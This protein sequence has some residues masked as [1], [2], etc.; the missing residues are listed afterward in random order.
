[1]GYSPERAEKFHWVGAYHTHSLVLIGK[2]SKN[3]R[4]ASLADAQKYRVGAVREDIG[5]QLLVAKGFAESELALSNIQNS[6]FLKLQ[7]DRLDLI[8]YM[9]DVA[10]KNMPRSGLDPQKYEIVFQVHELK[11]GFGFSKQIPEGVIK[12]FQDALNTL[13]L[14][15]SIDLILKKYDIH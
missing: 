6:L 3:I 13:F 5:H 8:S 14:D 2:K 15:G 7:A 12:Q 10:F 4:I 1:M 9:D 11:S